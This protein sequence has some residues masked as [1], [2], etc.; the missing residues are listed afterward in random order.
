M[1]HYRKT[2]LALSVFGLIGFATP[3]FADQAASEFQATCK[4]AVST[5]DKMDSLF[6]QIGAR[7]SNSKVAANNQVSNASAETTARKKVGGKKAKK[8]KTTKKTP[9]IKKPKAEKPV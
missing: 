1:F 2:S 9:A 6:S 5:L 3:V 4:Q 8:S 7:K